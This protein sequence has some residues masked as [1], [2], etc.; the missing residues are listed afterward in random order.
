MLRRLL[1][2]SRREQNKNQT[3]PDREMLLHYSRASGFEMKNIIETL[4]VCEAERQ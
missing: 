3:A 4:M 2:P 1:C